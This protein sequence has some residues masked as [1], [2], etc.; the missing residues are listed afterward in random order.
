MRPDADVRRAELADALRI[1]DAMRQADQDECY[2]STGLRPRQAVEVSLKVSDRAWI[3][4]V[5]EEPVVLFGVAPASLLGDTAAPWLLGTDQVVRHQVQFLRSC[6]P[7]LAAMRSRWPHL[8]NHVDVRNVTSIRW[9]KW[10]GFRF[11]EARPYGPFGLPFHR[12]E[13]G[14][15]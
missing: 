1:A 5:Q 7:Y 9:L 8:E 4:Y 14:G 3:G 15:S 10:L 13:L 12:F 6:R 11:H 2:A